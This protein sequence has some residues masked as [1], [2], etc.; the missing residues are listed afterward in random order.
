MQDAISDLQDSLPSL[1]K[2]VVIPNIYSDY[3]TTDLE[4]AV[5]WNDIKQG[6]GELFFEQVPFD[7]P[8]WILYSSGT[9]GHPKA[10]VQGHGGT[11]LE[12]LK[13]FRLHKNISEQDRFFWHT[14]TSL[15]SGWER[16][17]SIGLLRLFL[18]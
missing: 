12:H 2:T 8:L 4:N 3:K 1:R 18:K 7:H 11:I 17:K 10:I 16:V 15:A 5:L 13:T 9:S 14:S 6:E